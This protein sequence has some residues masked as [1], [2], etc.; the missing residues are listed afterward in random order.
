M[1]LDRAA[2]PHEQLA[3]NAGEPDPD[4]RRHDDLE[5]LA[6][7]IGGRRIARQRLGLAELRE[8]DAAGVVRG[9]LAQ[10][11]PQQ[12]DGRVRRAVGE[13][14]PG[15]FAQQHHDRGVA[16]RLTAQQVRADASAPRAFAGEHQA[17]A[18]VTVGE[19]RRR[20][21]LVHRALQQRM[22][23]RQ[24]SPTEPGSAPRSS[25]SAA[26][27]ARAPGIPASVAA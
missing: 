20:D 22:D 13:R 14:R 1:R 3:Q 4:R 7:V 12:P 2:V 18:T 9:R 6:Q 25:R 19:R 17:G 5:R 23:E 21:P 15:G 16:G 26:R 10:R 11:P 27:R 24:A 8:H